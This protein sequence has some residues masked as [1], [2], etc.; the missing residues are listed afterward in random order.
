MSDFLS[1]EEIDAL[2][3]EGEK[4]NTAPIMSEI[5][6]KE[7]AQE[8]KLALILEIPVI[9][10]VIL[11]E[12][13][14]SLADLLKLKP[15]LVVE[16]ENSVSEPVGLYVNDKLVAW[17][18]VVVVAEQFALRIKQIITPEERVRQMKG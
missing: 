2:L 12:T 13:N 3:A 9:A 5:L 6:Y 17:G 4:S 14:K 1:Q 11:G 15:G 16:T 18:E 8:Q 10:R 7:D